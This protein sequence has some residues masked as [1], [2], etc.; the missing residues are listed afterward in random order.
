MFKTIVLD[1][2]YAGLVKISVS[3]IHNWDTFTIAFY[4]MVMDQHSKMDTI[5]GLPL[6][7]KGFEKK[8]NKFFSEQPETPSGEGA[9]TPK[10]GVKN[11]ELGTG[12]STPANETSLK[13]AMA[14]TLTTGLEGVVKKDMPDK[15]FYYEAGRAIPSLNTP[16]KPEFN[17]WRWFFMYNQTFTTVLFISCTTLTGLAIRGAI[18]LAADTAILVLN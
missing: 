12:L 14:N 6:S 10:A 13:S 16:G 8:Y 4:K 3:I 1:V 15:V 2:F 7:E 9:E 18:K 17:T 5:S 11:A